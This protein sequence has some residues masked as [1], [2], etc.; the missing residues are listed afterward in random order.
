MDEI[1]PLLTTRPSESV[2]L[3][4]P[5]LRPRH[6]ELIPTPCGPIKPWSELTCL[7]KV[8][9]CFTVTSLVGVLV[10]T[11]VNIY[12]QFQK[13]DS[14]EEESVSLIQLVGI[15]FCL[16]YITRGILQENRQE[17]IAFVLSVVLVMV[18]SVVNFTVLLPEERKSLLLV[19][20][21]CLLC[22]G[23]LH[24]VCATLLIQRPNMMAFRVGG[25]LESLQEQ[26]FLLSLCFS[27]VTFDLQAQLCLCILIITSSMSLSVSHIV[28]LGFGVIWACFTAATGA[29]AVLKE[30]KMLVWI[31]VLQNLPELA[32][33]IYLLY[34][35]IEDWGQGRSYSEEA[36]AITGSCISVL[37]KGVLFWSLFQL[38]HSFG[39]GLRERMF[40][41][42]QQ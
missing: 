5:N 35:V 19:R 16:Y 12:G 2:D 15:L 37:I 9:Y 27:L 42:R 4:S 29:V 25:A 18:R 10:L 23:L 38:Y 28:I 30:V 17:L 21:V 24:V 26:Y 31:F 41:S 14:Y 22:V 36:A 34:V 39:Q 32:Y 40:A 33:F 6:R 13:N 1:S 8:Y 3:P 11:L 7:V 20:F